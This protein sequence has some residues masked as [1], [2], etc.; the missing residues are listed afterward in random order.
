MNMP[1][2]IAPPPRRV[3]V[4]LQIATIFGGPAQI[5][6]I[7]FALGMTFFLVF[8]G[9]ADLSF[10]TMRGALAE[11]DGR[12]TDVRST[13]ASEN[14]QAV[15]ANHYEY[16]VAGARWTGVSYTTGYAAR[17]GEEVTV[18]YKPERP[19]R[20][21]IAGMR[22]G[23]FGPGAFIS[24]IFP[25]IGLIVTIV[26]MRRGFRRTRMLAEGVLAN[27]K[28][29]DKKPTNM[30]VNK[31]RVYALTFEFTARDGR[32]CETTVRTHQTRRL[33]DEHVEPLLY[34]PEHPSRA[35]VLDEVA[36]RPMFDATGDLEPRPI[37]AVVYLILPAAVAAA[38]WYF[39]VRPS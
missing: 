19:S 24:G 31:Q 3:P 18:E 5:G 33:E 38:L 20:S 25:L 29:I 6:W 34:D 10:V 27:G 30:R 17:T 4:S 32:R 14:R 37:A 11:T 22:T 15:M 23:V 28:L 21:R 36:A 8:A 9:Q 1:P 26:S 2:R 35:Y 16:S 13:G 12:V 39:T 7:I